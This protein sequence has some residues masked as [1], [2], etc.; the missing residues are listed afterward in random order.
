MNKCFF[1]PA[2]DRPMWLLWFV[3]SIV[4]LLAS[5]WLDMRNSVVPVGII[6]MAY[7]GYFL[8]SKTLGTRFAKPLVE[9]SDDEVSFRNPFN[10]P[11]TVDRVP[12]NDLK[13]IEMVGMTD[14]RHIRCTFAD[15]SNRDIGPFSFSHEIESKLVVWLTIELPP[16][17]R[18]HQRDAP[19]F[20]EQVRGDW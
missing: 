4:W 2:A 6:V 8:L 12:L 19:T 9:L 3:F 18:V 11:A 7:L 1:L 13:V 20:F 5:W 14:R 16:S 10:I 15:G 17:T